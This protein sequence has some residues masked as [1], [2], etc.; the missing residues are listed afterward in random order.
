[1]LFEFPSTRKHEIEK[2]QVSAIAFASPHEKRTWIIT[3]SPV[4]GGAAYC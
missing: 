2:Q 4:R 1:M 3:I